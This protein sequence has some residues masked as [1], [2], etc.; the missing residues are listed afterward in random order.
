MKKIGIALIASFGIFIL[1]TANSPAQSKFSLKVKGGYTMIS[2][3]DLDSVITSH[4]RLFEDISLNLGM[5]REGRLEKLSGG[6]DLEGEIMMMLTRKIGIGLGL[7]YIQSQKDSSTMLSFGSLFR[8]DSDMELN[9]R[10]IPIK[11]DGFYFIPLS[12]GISFFLNGGIGYYIGK[13]NYS[14]DMAEEI[15]DF[16]S[17][18]QAI[19][20]V[21]D[22]GI[23]YHAGLG[24]E[25]RLADSVAIFLDA[26]GRYVKLRNWEGEESSFNSEGLRESRSGIL[27]YYEAYDPDFQKSY[28]NLLLSE[29]QPEVSGADN[30]RK[31]EID[32]SG[33]SLRLG[34]RLLF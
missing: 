3:H 17:S 8:L 16:S 15:L 6:I 26:G 24:I 30:S 13:M 19:G 7:G 33:L 27:W 31:L 20:T 23:G 29:N 4:D 34:I 10:A 12:S 22:K 28:S 14:F 2:F 25:M 1:L 21:E 9:I 18:S 32:L 5:S 11:L